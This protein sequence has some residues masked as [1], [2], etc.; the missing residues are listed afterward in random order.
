MGNTLLILDS[1]RIYCLC[2]LL[3]IGCE[4]R[5]KGEAGPEIHEESL[6]MPEGTWF[7]GLS[8]LFLG[9]E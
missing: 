9:P 2:I 1:M 5:M 7:S 3:H 6:V 4:S 8:F